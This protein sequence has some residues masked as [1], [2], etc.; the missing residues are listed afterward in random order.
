MWNVPTE[1]ESS[2]FLR[3]S[4]NQL[5]VSFSRQSNLESGV[6]AIPYCHHNTLPSLLRCFYK[7]PKERQSVAAE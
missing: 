7:T 5:K 6:A 1:F 3:A 4:A 2:E